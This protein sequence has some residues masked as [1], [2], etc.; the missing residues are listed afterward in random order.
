MYYCAAF[1]WVLLYGLTLTSTYCANFTPQLVAE[2]SSRGGGFERAELAEQRVRDLEA[3]CE[4]LQ[5]DNDSARDLLDEYQDRVAKAER[6]AK[7]H[8]RKREEVSDSEA[9]LKQLLDRATDDLQRYVR[10]Q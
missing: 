1:L 7:E 10:C 4:R 3:R 6:E 5:L 2:L 9:R 8:A